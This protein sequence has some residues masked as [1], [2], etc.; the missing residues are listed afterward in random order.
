F[1]NKMPIAVALRVALSQMPGQ[2]ATYLIRVDHIEV[3]TYKAARVD[4]RLDEGIVVDFRGSS[5]GRVIEELSERTGVSIGTHADLEEVLKK[6]FSLRSNGDM[7]LR[8]V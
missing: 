4:V 5:A 3:T 7:S 6:P 2:N 1:L 8:G